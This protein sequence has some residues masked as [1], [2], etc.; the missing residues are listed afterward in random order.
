LAGPNFQFTPAAH[1]GPA[2]WRNA[3]HRN[4]DART[5]LYDL[6]RLNRKTEL[7]RFAG[8]LAALVLLSGC[9]TPEQW[10]GD[11]IAAY[12]PYCDKLGYQRDTDAW[13][14]C[15]QLEDAKHSAT[16]NSML[17]W[18]QPA[19]GCRRGRWC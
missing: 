12:G 9:A 5:A 16:Q 1:S 17:M 15:V 7:V 10:A 11:V 18:S 4:L 2:E 8:W 14:Q 19:W 3:I 13:R 6:P